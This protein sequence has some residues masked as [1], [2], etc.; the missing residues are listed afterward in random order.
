MQN[1]QQFQANAEKLAGQYGLAAKPDGRI[2]D[3]QVDL[4][5]V[6]EYVG[7]V[8][9]Y[10]TTVFERELALSTVITRD[11]W[12]SLM[13]SVLAKRVQWA[14]MRVTGVRDGNRTIQIGNTFNVPGPLFQLFYS[15]GAVSS[16]ALGCVFLPAWDGFN[17]F[18]DVPQGAMGKYLIFVGRAKHY[19]IFS[20]G[21]PAKETGSWTYMLYATVTALGTVITG[22]TKEGRP[23]DAFLAGIVRHTR[24]MAGLMYG[25]TYGV[26]TDPDQATA[27]YI[28][29][30]ARGIGEGVK[31]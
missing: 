21:L 17:A 1:D 12:V 5:A 15:F 3:V 7:K 24:L 20:E 14:R 18:L 26:I 22:P 6:I 2:I 27:Q 31:S 30:Y 23:A 11:E 28:G 19:M 8:Y 10:L 25:S 4:T 16:D 29:S 9:D 13:M